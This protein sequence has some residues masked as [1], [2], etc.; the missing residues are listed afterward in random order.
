[1]PS[2]ETSTKML[3]MVGAVVVFGWGVFQFNATQHQQNE[4][5]RIEATKPFLERQLALYTEVTQVASTIATT[6]DANKKNQALD[7]FW[8]LYWGELALVEDAFV[9]GAMVKLGE[10]LRKNVDNDDIKQQALGLAHACRNSLARSWGVAA[11]QS[12]HWWT[13]ETTPSR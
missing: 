1:M 3:S 13:S 6:T 10:A 9:E 4:S 2:L 11:W 12:P 5:R 7:R 8:S